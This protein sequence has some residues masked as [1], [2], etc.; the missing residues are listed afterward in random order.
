M[1]YKL[2]SGWLWEVIPIETLHMIDRV[3]FDKIK[4]FSRDNRS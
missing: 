1:R 4:K 3:C 2:K